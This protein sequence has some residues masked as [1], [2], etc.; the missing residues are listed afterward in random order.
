MQELILKEE[1]K[2]FIDKKTKARTI[3]LPFRLPNGTS[4][5]CMICQLKDIEW[6]PN[7]IIKSI[8]INY[9]EN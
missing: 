7:K 8:T 6:Q 3:A 4:A 1:I 5:V 2:V 9:H